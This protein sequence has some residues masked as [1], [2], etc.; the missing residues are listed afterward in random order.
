VTD[1]AAPVER[2]FS[3]CDVADGDTVRGEDGLDWRAERAPGDDRLVILTPTGGG[4][5]VYGRPTPTSVVTV[6][7][8]GEYGAAIDL[9]G[10]VLGAEII[11]EGR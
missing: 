11:R 5:P 8:R 9:L 1:S 10:A 7:R 3:W 2:V 6:V 4:P